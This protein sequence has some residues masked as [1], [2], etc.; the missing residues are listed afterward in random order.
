MATSS[1]KSHVTYKRK[2]LNPRRLSEEEQRS[3]SWFSNGIESL[4]LDTI[5]DLVEDISHIEKNTG[6]NNNNA[7]PIGEEIIDVE[8]FEV[9]EPPHKKRKVEEKSVAVGKTKAKLKRRSSGRD[10]DI[11]RAV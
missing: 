11:Q 9:L 4:E 5:Q 10:L 8:E 7:L 6:A 3:L 1:H 2:S